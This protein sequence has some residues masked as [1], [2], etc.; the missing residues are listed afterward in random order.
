[1]TTSWA[2][3][4]DLTKDLGEDPDE[5]DPNAAKAMS[6]ATATAIPARRPRNAAIVS[7]CRSGRA[8]EGA[9]S[10]AGENAHS[11]A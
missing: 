5:T 10:P 7:R 11:P 8:A 1:M 9:Q 4:V 6:A 3:T 2:L